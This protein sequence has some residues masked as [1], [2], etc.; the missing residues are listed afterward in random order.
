MERD[1]TAI[2]AESAVVLCC[3]SL[4]PWRAEDGAPVFQSPGKHRNTGCGRLVSLRSVLVEA[5]GEI[6]LVILMTRPKFARILNPRSHL[7]LESHLQ[8]VRQYSVTEYSLR[9]Q[10]EMLREGPK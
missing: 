5:A 3:L 9:S 10:R 2:D 1:S 7:D 8:A 4:E 6:A